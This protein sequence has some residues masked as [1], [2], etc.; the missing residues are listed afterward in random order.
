MFIFIRNSLCEIACSIF[1]RRAVNVALTLTLYASCHDFAIYIRAVRINH[2]KA[3][4]TQWCVMRSR[5]IHS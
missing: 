4:S 2:N 1:I 3:A 5:T